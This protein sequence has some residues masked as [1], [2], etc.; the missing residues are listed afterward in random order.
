MMEAIAVFIVRRDDNV[1]LIQRLQKEDEA[2]HWVFPADTVDPSDLERSAKDSVNDLLGITPDTIDVITETEHTSETNAYYV[3]V[4]VDDS[5]NLSKEVL[6]T[7]WL[8][9]DEIDEL[10]VS[11]NE[12]VRQA[13]RN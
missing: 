4:D 2:S 1:L 10:T 8:S 3:S 13:I 6:R 11:I 9:P 7:R 5:F 12:D